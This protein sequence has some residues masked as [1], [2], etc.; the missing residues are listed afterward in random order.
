[1]RMSERGL[2]VTVTALNT[3]G[4]FDTTSNGVNM[5]Y[6]NRCMIVYQF[7]CTNTSNATVTLKQGTS[8]TADTAL[9]FTEYSKNEDCLNYPTTFTKVTATTLTTAGPAAGTCMY[10]F[11]VKADQLNTDTF[12]SENTYIR[13]DSE[14]SANVTAASLTYYMYEP[15]VAKSTDGMPSI[16]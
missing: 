15:R 10:I 6:Y 3:D 2:P 11:E 7:T 9:A 8:S 12:G 1:M 14:S 4:D 5:K 16:A 13:L